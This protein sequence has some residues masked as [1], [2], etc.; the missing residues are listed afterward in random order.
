MSEHCTTKTTMD[1]ERIRAYCLAFPNATENLQ[2][3]DDLC[4]KIGG[5]I[6]ATLALTAVPQKM[7]FKCTPEIFA[8]LIE[9]EDI[10]PA[11]YVGRY[12]WVILHR[13]DALNAHELE[14]FVRQSYSMVA[15][16][17]PKAKSQA[18]KPRAKSAR[19][20]SR[21]KAAGRGKKKRH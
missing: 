16:N 6:F 14:E 1:V 7:C 19:K 2:W 15:A 11:P 5:K 13:L 10:A 17:A 20:P 12:K 4:F 9:R 21:A 18:S 8:E 3:G